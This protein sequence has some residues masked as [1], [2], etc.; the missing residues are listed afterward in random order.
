MISHI[1][2]AQELVRVWGDGKVPSLL[3]YDNGGKLRAAGAEVLA[4]SVIER[5]LDEGWT[6]AEWLVVDYVDA[7]VNSV[8]FVRFRWKLHLRPK[9]STSSNDDLPPLP[10]G[11]SAVDVF[12]DFIKYLFQ[13]AKSYIQERH[14]TFAWSS[15]E[16]SAEYILTYPNGWEELPQQLYRQAV[17][18]AGLIPN[19]PEG[20]S[21]VHL[22]TE[23][24]A[25]LHF[26][27]RNLLNKTVNLAT[28]QGITVIDAGGVTID[29]SMFC[30]KSDPISC[31]EIAPAECTQP[32]LT[33]S[34]LL[35]HPY[36]LL[37]RLQGS[38]FVTHRARTLLQSLWLIHPI[39]MPVP[40]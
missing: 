32:S 7:F 25:S 33:A 38:I 11:K 40:S 23:G 8:S 20:R 34:F 9:H 10:P 6:R 22:L 35:I 15:V 13:C 4:E 2:P 16:D 12:A 28:A 3:Y 1:F 19:T 37:G 39:S 5:A 24:E 26:C 17:E 27:A 21:R 30:M 36:L 14:L 18:R 31:E 29:L